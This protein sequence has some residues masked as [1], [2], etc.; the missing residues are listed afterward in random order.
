MKGMF[1]CVFKAKIMYFFTCFSV[2]SALDAESAQLNYVQNQK[3]NEDPETRKMR[4]SSR[5]TEDY[6]LISMNGKRQR[7]KDEFFN[8]QKQFGN[9]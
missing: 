9:V 8:R 3:N 4:L 6:C 1:N 5:N 2:S 7:L